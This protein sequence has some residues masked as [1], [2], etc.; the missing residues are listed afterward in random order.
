MQYHVDFHTFVNK[1]S[2]ASRQ[3]SKMGDHLEERINA[4]ER[5]QEE[6]GHE[7]REIKQQLKWLTEMAQGSKVG[8]MTFALEPSTITE[9]SVHQNSG[10]LDEA[11]K[12]MKKM[13]AHV[14]ETK[15]LIESLKITQASQPI[16]HSEQMP[17]PVNQ[18]PIP[19]VSPLQVYT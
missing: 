15:S 19:L 10:S 9:G 11:T 12:E 2:F 1:N 14:A 17:Y 16:L 7:I 3:G 8:Q 4:L 13:S 18:N 5:N 6:F